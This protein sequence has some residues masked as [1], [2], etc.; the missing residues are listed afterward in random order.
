MP[1]V[2]TRTAV[3]PIG[4]D[5]MFDTMVKMQPKAALHIR[6]PGRAGRPSS[7][8]SHSLYTWYKN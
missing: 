2:D 8:V 4:L 7:F 6:L 5:P 1:A 3:L